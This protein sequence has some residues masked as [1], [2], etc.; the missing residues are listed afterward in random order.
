MTQVSGICAAPDSA[1]VTSGSS[2]DAPWPS[3]SLLPPPPTVSALWEGAPIGT[4]KKVLELVVGLVPSPPKFLAP[5]PHGELT[6]HLRPRRL[7][8]H[9]PHPPP[10]HQAKLSY[11]PRAH[12]LLV[13]CLFGY[14]SIPFLLIDAIIK[15][16]KLLLMVC[17][18]TVRPRKEEG[19][20]EPI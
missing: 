10:P 9:P 4:T 1:T 6:C 3:S 2:E 16:L 7:T 14:F 20:Q 13:K 8:P 18:H 12:Y 11:N 17:I 19:L 15:D 5:S